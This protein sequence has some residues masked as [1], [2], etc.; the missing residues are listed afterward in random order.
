VSPTPSSAAPS[1]HELMDRLDRQTAQIERLQGEVERLR[2]AAPTPS[3]RVE[4]SAPDADV[5]VVTRRGLLG[6]A[7][8]AA[9]AATVAAAVVPSPADATV[10]FMRFGADNEAGLDATSLASNHP[11][12]TLEVQNNS[13]SATS[14][15][16]FGLGAGS[17]IEGQIGGPGDRGNGVRGVTDGEGCGVLGVVESSFDLPPVGGTGVRGTTNGAGSGVVG[18]VTAAASHGFGVKGTTVGPA[19]AVYGKSS[20]AAGTAAVMGDSVA[21]TK[22][23]WGRNG[24]TNPA[25]VG[26]FGESQAGRGASF[27]GKLAQ[28]RLRPSTATTH[29]TGGSPGDF[30]VDST[31]RLWFC[32]GGGVWKQLA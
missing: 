19:A 22:A 32:K 10:G 11:S 2:S 9:G 31:A 29:P 24:G 15:R 6:K 8:A 26:V 17:A 4:P 21:A 16:V 27:G 20:H 23:V 12:T 28:L 30:F 5:S 3:R 25:G 14:L 18:E 1:L 7:G 13:G